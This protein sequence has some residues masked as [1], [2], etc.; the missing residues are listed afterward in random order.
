[1]PLDNLKLEDW[2]DWCESD[3]LYIKF[4]V[5]LKVY[6]CAHVTVRHI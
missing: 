2:D 1:M 5:T 6:S 3:S 4:K